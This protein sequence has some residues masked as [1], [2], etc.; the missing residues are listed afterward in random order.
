MEVLLSCCLAVGSRVVCLPYGLFQLPVGLP[1]YRV[2][3]YSWLL[4]CF[5]ARFNFSC[6]YHAASLPRMLLHI[7]LYDCHVCVCLLLAIELL[8]YH[9]HAI[10]WPSSY[11]KCTFSCP[12]GH[13]AGW[14]LHVHL[15]LTIGLI[16]M[17]F[18]LDALKVAWLPCVLFQ[19]PS[20]S[21]PV[22][23][24]A[25]S[26]AIYTACVLPVWHIYYLGV[27]PLHGKYVSCCVTDTCIA[28]F[29]EP[30]RQPKYS[31]GLV[32]VLLSWFTLCELA[33][34]L[35]P[36]LFR[37]TRF[38][39]LQQNVI[40]ISD[41]R[42]KSYKGMLWLYLCMFALCMFG[43]VLQAAQIPETLGHSITIAL[44]F[45]NMMLYNLSH[46]SFVLLCLYGISNIHYASS[47]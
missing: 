44:F 18:P 2:C 21:C 23:T 46:I 17:C 8:D 14:L 30:V 40:K 34:S 11:Y 16:A 25:P 26:G 36:G 15:H 1:F 4:G 22:A 43:F 35:W 10:I 3:F 38:T 45:L 19:V 32:R 33:W 37:D 28:S 31:Q 41:S 12:F 27:D 7:W 9:V 5:S 6:C 13:W 47:I 20:R 29:A 42:H 39:F 24:Y